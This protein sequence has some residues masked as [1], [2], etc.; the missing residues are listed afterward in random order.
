MFIATRDIILTF[1]AIFCI[2]FIIACVVA[3]MVLKGWELGIVESI[4][5][6]IAI[7]LSVDYVVH[8]SADYI[9][10][11]EKGRSKRMQQAY[12]NMGISIVS[13]TITTMGSSLF[14]FGG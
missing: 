7:G 14:L 10:S 11:Q 6:V 12:K 13:G 1:M 3:I 5:I 9:H 2:S 8:L 4:G